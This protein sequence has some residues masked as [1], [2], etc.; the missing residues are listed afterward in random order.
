MRVRARAPA[1]GA[2]HLP[3]APA[4][5]RPA[6]GPGPRAERRAGGAARGHGQD[7]PRRLEPRVCGRGPVFCPPRDV[8]SSPVSRPFTRP[9]LD[10][11]ARGHA[12]VARSRAGHVVTRRPRGNVPVTRGCARALARAW[13]DTRSPLRE[14]ATLDAQHTHTHTLSLSLPRPHPRALHWTP[15]LTRARSG[16]GYHVTSITSLRTP[17]RRSSAAVFDWTR[18][19]AHALRHERER[20]HARAHAR[21]PRHTHT[22]RGTALAP[23]HARA[24]ES[25]ARAGRASP[26]LVTRVSSRVVAR[27]SS[28]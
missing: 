27:V 14:R 24:R 18:A 22:H 23:A 2:R 16:P 10:Y 17:S 4:R 20:V 21:V 8:I 28:R 25:L 19:R 3:R 6:R 26:W 7:D 5:R 9:P 1:G 15:A 12:P 11:P 13:I